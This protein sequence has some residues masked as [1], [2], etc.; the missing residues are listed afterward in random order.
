MINENVDVEKAVANDGS[1]GQF[2]RLK[3]KNGWEDVFVINID[4]I[5]STV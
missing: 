3:L 1:V 4:G 5:I 2:M